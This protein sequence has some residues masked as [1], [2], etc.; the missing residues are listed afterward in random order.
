MRVWCR[1][2]E[3]C[4]VFQWL[5]VMLGAAFDK[6]RIFEGRGFAAT[7]SSG[8]LTGRKYR[9]KPASRVLKD[10]EVSVH[11]D[12]RYCFLEL[13]C[14]NFCASFRSP[15]R[16]PASPQRVQAQ[17]SCLTVQWR[18]CLLS[19]VDDQL[20]AWLSKGQVV[21]VSMQT[22]RAKAPNALVNSFLRL[23]CAP[24]HVPNYNGLD[25]RQATYSGRHGISISVWYLARST[26]MR[27]CAI[28]G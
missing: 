12:V 24:T 28:V 3:Q 19:P 25:L 1:R 22:A 9:T 10:H 16:N 14:R 8:H 4:V 2:S 13:P 6:P 27:P 23:P 17:A 5:F 18:I 11:L 20:W 7:S 15:S 26:A 21:A